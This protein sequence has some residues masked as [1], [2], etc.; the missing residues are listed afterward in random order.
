MPVRQL[1]QLYLK[2][3][4]FFAPVWRLRRSGAKIGKNVFIGEKVYV[5][6]E[7]AN[8]L[9][10]QS[11]AVLSAFTKVIL[12]DSSLNNVKGFEV[13][14][15]RVV[16]KRNAYIGAGAIL[17]P[18]TVVGE[19]TIVGA[20]SLVKGVLKDGSVYAGVPARYIGTTAQMQIRWKKR[21]DK[22]VFLRGS[23]KWYEKDN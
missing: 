2:I 11:G 19:N 22:L 12:H 18:G 20:G 5:E 14:Y 6:L 21:K 23:K 16:V 10:I 3:V 8:L 9:E 1:K 7:N 4:F 15:G 17:L 13:L